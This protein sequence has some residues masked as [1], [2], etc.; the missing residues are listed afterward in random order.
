MNVT[1][2]KC[3]KRYSIAD[4]KVRGKSVK[5]R[6]KQCQNLIS[7]Q[8]PAAAAPGGLEL[9]G[10][11]AVAGSP[12]EEER[13]RAMPAMD[14]TAQWFAMVKGKQLGP[15]DLKGLEGKVKTGELTLRT[16]L[17]KQGMGDWKRASDVP[18]V[19]PVFAGV[20]VGATATGPT[21]FA[22]AERPSSKRVLAVQRDVA[23]ALETPSPEVTARKTNGNGNGNGHGHPPIDPGTQPVPRTTKVPSQARAPVAARPAEPAPVAAQE[24]KPLSDLFGENEHVPSEQGPIGDLGTEENSGKSQP[25]DPFAAL[26]EVDPSQAPPPGEATKFFIAQAGVNKRNPPWKIALFVI[27]APGLIV[28]VLFLLSTL[29]IVPLQVTRTNEKGEEVK[30]SFFSAGGVS[31]IKDLFSG[32]AAKKKA[33]A[34]KAKQQALEQ[35][36]RALAAANSD[37]PVAQPDKP[38]RPDRPVEPK[39]VDPALA[40]IYGNGQDTGT[41]GP[42]VRLEDRGQTKTVDSTGLTQ[43]A[44]QKVIADKIK[45]F[46]GCIEQALRRNPNLSVGPIDVQLNVGASGAVTSASIV[47]A[48]HNNS[49]WG[50]CMRDVAK[51]IVFPKSDGETE[52]SLPLKVGVAMSP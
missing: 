21:S 26:G 40:L 20:S 10:G 31:G 38:D 33:D 44:T 22:S 9:G 37:R 50:G 47:P 11:P 24:A 51:R 7:V 17:W 28:G 16:Y 43:E 6:C 13:T 5:I 29:Q 39:P 4:D 3:N 46:E 8:G 42:R 14:N 12:W 34:E 49:D 19:S 2:D 52:V 35:R 27:G 30:E 18:E 36:R 45:A 15:F 25:D 41:K 32:E 48:K 1:C 23:V